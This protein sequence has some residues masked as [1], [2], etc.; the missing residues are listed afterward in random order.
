MAPFHVSS[1]RRRLTLRKIA[2]Q[3][4][5]DALSLIGDAR[6]PGNIR[7]AVQSICRAR[8]DEQ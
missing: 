2:L 4:R 3:D 8:K 5:R 6:S 7:G 1:S